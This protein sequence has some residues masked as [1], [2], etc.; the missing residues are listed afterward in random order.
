MLWVIAAEFM[1]G[2][3]GFIAIS[4]VLVLRRWRRFTLHTKLMLAG[5]LGLIGI[6]VVG[7][8]VLEWDN[9]DTLGGLPSAADKLQAAWFE[10]VTP[11]TAGFNAVDTSATRESTALLTMALL[12]VSVMSVLGPLTLG[13]FLAN[14]TPPRVKYP[15]GEVFLG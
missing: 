11:K 14:K 15:E 10:G 8:G 9:P 7:Y 5:T 3:L 12:T 4:D 2:G 1:L 6:S 13:F